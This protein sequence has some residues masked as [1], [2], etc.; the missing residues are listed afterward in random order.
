MKCSFMVYRF[1]PAVDNEPRYEE[2]TIE[3]EATDKI[4]DCLNKIRWEQDATLSYRY[5]CAHGICGS[6]ALMINGRIGLA[7]QKLVRD[8]KTANNQGPGGG[9]R[10]ILQEAPFR[11]ALPDQ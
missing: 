11:A 7:C 1:D 5:S 8:F 4:L 10:S 3:A 2:F 9:P 6:D